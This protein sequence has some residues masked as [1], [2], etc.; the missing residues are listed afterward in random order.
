MKIG[1]SLYEALWSYVGLDGPHLTDAQFRSLVDLVL[2][3]LRHAGTRRIMM[4]LDPHIMLNFS[5]G[6]AFTDANGMSVSTTTGWE[7]QPIEETDA[8][9]DDRFLIVD[10]GTIPF[11]LIAQKKPDGGYNTLV[12]IDQPMIEGARSIL[13][14]YPVIIRSS[15]ATTVE[16]YRRAGRMIARIGDTF[17]ANIVSSWIDKALQPLETSALLNALLNASGAVCPLCR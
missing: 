12:S 16:S 4:R 3:N 7:V 15:Q 6:I 10:D 5:S 9:S 2:E 8:L 14:G 1:L 11:V 13:R 17:N